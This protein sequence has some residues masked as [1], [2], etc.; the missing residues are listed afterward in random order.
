MCKAMYTLE[1]KMGYP[2]EKSHLDCVWSTL[3]E[4]HN[5]L[6]DTELIHFPKWMT[7]EAHKWP[8]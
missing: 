6:N 4:L 5:F 1:I 8:T 3:K 2:M 7:N